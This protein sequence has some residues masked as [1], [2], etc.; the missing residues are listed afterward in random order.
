MFLPSGLG[1]PFPPDLADWTARIA[2]AGGATLSEFSPEQAVRRPHFERRNRMIAALGAVAFAVE[3]RR[4]SGTTMTARLA[5]DLG[6]S[7]AVLPGSAMDPR[8]AG[9]LD[10]LS[11]GA[12]MIRD[13]LDLQA[14][15]ES[16]HRRLSASL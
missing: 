16:E 10:F 9:T 7:L 6:R 2:A 3:G 14:L 8:A 15:L 13:S 12:E 11:A 1:C 4:R 5:L